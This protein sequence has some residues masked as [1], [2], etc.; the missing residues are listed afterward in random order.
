V[1]PT[2]EL[3]EQL[4]ELTCHEKDPEKRLAIVREIDRLLEEREN[5]A[6]TKRKK[7]SDPTQSSMVPPSSAT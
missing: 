2:A 7:Q 5:D 1:E 3:W 6:T 4:T